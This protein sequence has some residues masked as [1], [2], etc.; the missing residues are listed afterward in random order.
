VEKADRILGFRTTVSL[1]QGLREL[2]RW[3]EAA[4]V[5]AAPVVEAS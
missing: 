2:I 1:E 4:K 5:M 3:R